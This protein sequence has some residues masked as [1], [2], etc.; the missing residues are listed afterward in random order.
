MDAVVASL[1]ALSGDEQ[2][3]EAASLLRTHDVEEL[4][5]NINPAGPTIAYLHFLYVPFVDPDM[6][7]PSL[8]DTYNNNVQ[9]P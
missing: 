2:L 7:L 6:Y 1:A 4:L 8:R 3:K 5:N 9:T